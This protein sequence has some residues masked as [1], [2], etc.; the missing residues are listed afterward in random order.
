MKKE[1]YKLLYEVEDYY[2]W[3][4]S[5]RRTVIEFFKIYELNRFQFLKVLDLGCG[6]GGMLVELK[7]QGIHNIYGVDKETLAISLAMKRGLK[8]LLVADAIAL[9]FKEG[10]FD[11][12]IALDVLE[13]IEFDDVALK[14]IY[15]SLSSGGR[16]I[17]TVPA[18][19][20]LWSDR[21]TRLGHYR[22]YRKDELRGKLKNAGFNILK[23]TY[24]DLFYLLPA[25]MVYTFNTLFGRETKIDVVTVPLILNSLFKSLLSMERRLLKKFSFPIGVS[26]FCLAEK[27]D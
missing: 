19:M 11:V 12:V 15:R 4:V 26:I 21:D 3:S 27:G 23:M 7:N 5:R 9:P 18:L 6:T 25:K 16:L 10:I 20:W 1:I 8:E 14:E 22:R 17:L 2:W 24:I 13:H